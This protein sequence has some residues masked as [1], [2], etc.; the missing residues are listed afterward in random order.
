[1]NA[2]G[3]VLVTGAAGA[4]GSRLLRVLGERGWRRRGLVHKRRVDDADETVLGGL[5]DAEALGRAVDGVDAIVHLAAVTHSRSSK[6]YGEVNAEGTRNLLTAARSA[7]VTR[8]VQ[9]S[10]RAI[11][12]DGGAYSRSKLEAEE[13]VR[14]SE[15]DWTIVRLPEVYGAGGAEGLD[16]VLVRVREGRRVPIVGRGD[17]VLCPVYV[18]DVVRACAVALESPAALRQT[19]TLAGPSLTMRELVTLAGDVL[20]RPARTVEVP[21]AV[22]ATLASVSRVIPLPLYPDQLARLRSEKPPASPEAETVLEFRARSLRD[23][24]TQVLASG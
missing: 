1:M 4:V 16:Q 13:A 5:S 14:S 12:P 22:V 6:E 15:L 18:D 7:D 24:L 23:G 21:V 20:G 8:F 11:S 2:R 10:T 17:A 9:I 19:Y 3:T